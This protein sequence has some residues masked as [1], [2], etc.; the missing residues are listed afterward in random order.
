MWQRKHRLSSSPFSGGRLQLK[1]AQCTLLKSTSLS[2]FTVSRN[3]RRIAHSFIDRSGSESWLDVGSSKDTRSLLLPP[4]RLVFSSFFT[5]RESTASETPGTVV[6]LFS[7]GKVKSG[8]PANFFSRK[9]ACLF[10]EWANAEGDWF[11]FRQRLLTGYASVVRPVTSLLLSLALLGVLARSL[12]L[13]VNE[14]ESW[15]R[16][17]FHEN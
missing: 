13:T 9:H 7:S 3:L 16:V 8:F 1:Q 14:N 2:I 5:H 17:I 15:L 6:M 4:A 11:F 12:Q 10:L